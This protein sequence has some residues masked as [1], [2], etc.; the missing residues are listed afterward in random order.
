[1]VVLTRLNGEKFAINDEQI[2]RMEA[3]HDTTVILVTGNRYTVV[4]SIDQIIDE[5]IEFRGRVFEQDIH[6]GNAG[7]NTRI[8][9]FKPLPNTAVTED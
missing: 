7:R 5:I 3:G 2:E 6:V 4:E 9:A 1:M 8:A